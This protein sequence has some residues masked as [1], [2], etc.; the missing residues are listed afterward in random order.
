MHSL[1][2]FPFTIFVVSGLLLFESQFFAFNGGSWRFQIATFVGLPVLFATI[3]ALL[4]WRR[5]FLDYE[6]AFF[7]FWMA[8]VAL[9][10]MWLLDESPARWLGLDPQSPSGMAVGKV[11]DVAVIIITFTL[12]ARLFQVS[13]GSIYLQRGRLRLGL[14]IGFVG[15]AGMATFGV[16]EARSL[17][18]GMS[19]I[20]GWAPWLLIFVLG[21]GFVEEL[22]ARGLFLKKFEPLMGCHLSNLATALVFAI[23]HAG[24]TYTTDILPFLGLVFVFALVA[25]FVMQKTEAIWG[26]ALF[27]AGA[28]VV[29]MIGIFAGVK[30]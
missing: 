8:S 22:M 16:L 19:R 2:L 20:L 28:D 9:F 12:L 23:G 7:S 30:T 27:H 6:P 17:G 3:V 21:N 4:R 18:I 10:F 13:F 1:R 15:F 11:S 29:I 14:A 26:S 24:V 5:R 25:G